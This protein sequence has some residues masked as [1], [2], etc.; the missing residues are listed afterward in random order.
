M[1]S[2]ALAGLAAKRSAALSALERSISRVYENRG[3]DEFGN[4]PR[5]ARRLSS[6]KIIFDKFMR[7][8]RRKAFYGFLNGSS[9]DNCNKSVRNV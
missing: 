9:R 2:T 5:L 7:Q 1:T 3:D 4:F 6:T 8:P